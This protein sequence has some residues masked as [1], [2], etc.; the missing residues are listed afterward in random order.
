MLH[1]DAR[2]RTIT[3]VWDN[4]ERAEID[5]DCWLLLVRRAC[6]AGAGAIPP[7][8]DAGFPVVDPPMTARGRYDARRTL[9]ECS[10]TPG[11][12]DP[13]RHPSDD[14]PPGHQAH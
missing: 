2:S 8:R 14:R 10:T 6:A 5:G 11:A 4:G 9:D 3:V 12:A 13:S 1:R 7:S